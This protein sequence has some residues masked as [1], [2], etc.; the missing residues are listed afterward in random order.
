MHNNQ[1]SPN[2]L[3]VT[4]VAFS[5]TWAGFL[6]LHYYPGRGGERLSGFCKPICNQ[7]SIVWQ[8]SLSFCKEQARLVTNN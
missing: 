8:W 7:H 2:P 4:K 5:T 1:L 3:G 6:A